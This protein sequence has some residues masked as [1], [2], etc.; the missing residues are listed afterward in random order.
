M[1]IMIVIIIIIIINIRAIRRAVGA[2]RRAVGAY[3]KNSF[4]QNV[5]TLFGSDQFQ[6]KHLGT[7]LSI[8]GRFKMKVLITGDEKSLCCLLIKFFAP[9]VTSMCHTSS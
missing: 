2:I 9:T 7:C 5:I 3:E 8:G 1:I 6:V 4:L